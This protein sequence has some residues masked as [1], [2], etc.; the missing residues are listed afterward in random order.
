MNTDS[1]DLNSPPRKRWV[2]FAFILVLCFWVANYFYGS[3]LS[4][5]DRG[6]FGDM[7]GAVNSIFS[8]MAF[9]GVIYA[10]IMQRYEIAIARKDIAYT[11]KIL[12]S[13]NVQLKQQN[14]EAKKQ[15]FESTFFELL[16]LFTDLTIQI[17]LQRTENNVSILTRGKKV[18]PVF[19]NRLKAT[20]KPDQVK[21][22]GGENYN[23]AYEKFYSRHNT[24]LGHYFRTIYNLIK[25]ID[26]SEVPNKKFYSNIVR[27]QLSDA[28][29]AL[30]FHNGLSPYGSKKFK[31]L[32]EKYGLLKNVSDTDILDAKLKDVYSKSAF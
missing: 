19:L 31:P 20:Y 13:Q 3:S 18:F 1:D 27:A 7:F 17:E 28:E 10:I 23:K 9:V 32:I 30:L 22:F 21:L 12:D 29:A 4:N 11:K 14:R 6:T 25:F 5:E 24:E 26:V 15:I 2:I 8:G 16:R